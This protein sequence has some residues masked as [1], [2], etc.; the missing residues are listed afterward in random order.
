[1]GERVSKLVSD[2]NSF[3]PRVGRPIPKRGEND[4]DNG[5]LARDAHWG[6]RSPWFTSVPSVA[7][8]SVERCPALGDMHGGY[9]FLH[10]VQS[11]HPRWEMKSTEHETT[12]VVS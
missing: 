5:R 12:S 9:R 11:I 2:G 3:F 10:K 7:P 8:V 1:V 4:P 6:S